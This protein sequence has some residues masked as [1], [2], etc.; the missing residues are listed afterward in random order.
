MDFAHWQEPFMDENYV[1]NSKK[2]AKTSALSRF[3]CSAAKLKTSRRCFVGSISMGSMLPGCIRVDLRSLYG[4]FFAWSILG[5][6]FA[7][8]EEQ[9][10]SEDECE[11]GCCGC[12][13]ALCRSRSEE[14][15]RAVAEG[16]GGTL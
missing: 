10:L 4:I 5:F 6:L 13:A 7:F 9:G 12:A 2:C 15:N 8:A 11:N 3:F 1:E 16:E 14:D